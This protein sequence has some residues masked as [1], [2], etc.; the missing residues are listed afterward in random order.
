MAEKLVAVGRIV[1]THGLKG[2]VKLIPY[3][4]P[5]E[6]YE[7]FKILHVKPKGEEKAEFLVQ[8]VRYQKKFIILKLEGFENINAAEALLNQEVEI[9]A[10]YLPVL[11]ENEFYWHDLVGLSVYDE[12]GGFLGKVEEIF[13]TGSNDVLVVRREGEELLLPAIREVVLEVEL[14][15]GRLKVCPQEWLE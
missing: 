1:K 12:T 2:E 11:E 10:R 7:E 9:S 15:E 3:F 8:R 6:Q 4:E 14:K 5:F 13:P